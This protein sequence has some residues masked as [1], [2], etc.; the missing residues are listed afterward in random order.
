MSKAALQH[1][2]QLRKFIANTIIGVRD[3]D[4]TTEKA[5]VI[6]AGAKVINESLYSEIKAAVVMQALGREVPEIGKL[7]IFGDKVADI[8][9]LPKQ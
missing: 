9:R 8:G 6:V 5:S 7:E 3:G 1:T 4:I 2:E